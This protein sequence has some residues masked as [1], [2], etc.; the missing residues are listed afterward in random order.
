[1]LLLLNFFAL[2]FDD[3]EDL[4]VSRILLPD[5][6]SP[7]SVPNLGAY[8]D[9][10][11]RARIAVSDFVLGKTGVNEIIAGSQFTNDD[12]MERLEALEK[13]LR[14]SKGAGI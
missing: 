13:I 1:M 9:M 11:D 8:Q 4:I 12:L 5:L 7:I 14:E 6:R 10:Y 3:S 2:V